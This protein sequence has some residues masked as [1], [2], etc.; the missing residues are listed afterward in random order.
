MAFSCTVGDAS[1]NDQGG[2][3]SGSYATML[4]V[5]DYMY[6][7]NNSELHTI[8]ISDKQSPETIDIQDV[9]F[10]IE[11]IYHS[12]GVLFIGSSDNLYIYAI[13]QIGIPV[14][15]SNTV[16]NFN[17][18]VWCSLDPVIVQDSFAYVSLSSNITGPCGFIR[19]VDELRIYNIS[20][21]TNPE[22]ISI[23]QM[24]FPKGLAIKGD[25]V[26]VCLEQDGLVLVDVENKYQPQIIWSDIFAN[27]Y[28]LIWKPDDLLIVVSKGNLRQYDVTNLEDIELLSVFNL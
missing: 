21:L 16:Y 27:A 3:Q 7:V 19:T 12:D 28:D 8:D 17:D 26:F 22:L 4:I 13:N 20:D 1:F 10:N 15:Q 9:G 23:T 14:R 18:D 6:A 5:N 25:Y 2:T 11:N 24:P